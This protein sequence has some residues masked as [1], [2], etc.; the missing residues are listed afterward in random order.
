MSLLIPNAQDYKDARAGNEGLL[1]FHEKLKDLRQRKQ[2][3]WTFEVEQGYFYQS[4]DTTDDLKFN[5]ATSDFGVTRGW[6]EIVD[7][8]HQANTRDPNIHY[9]LLFLARH[10]QG[11]HNI[12]VNK[13][14]SEAWRNKWHA[15]ETD[16]DIKYAPDPELTD[17]GIAQAHENNQVWSEQLKKGC[18]LPTKFFVSPLQRLCETLRLTMKGLMVKDQKII[19]CERIRE[20]IGYHLCNKRSTKSIIVDRFAKYGFEPEDGFTEQDELYSDKEETFEENCLRVNSFLQ[21]LFST[22]DDEVINITSHGGTIKCFLAVTGH[23]NFTI[24]TGGMIPIVLKAT[25]IT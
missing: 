20:I 14:G 10:G 9:K 3:Q 11:Y 18:P 21:D 25:K 12:I 7:E 6:N 1:Q 22:Y 19:I 17:L 5:Y 23:R 24:S 4:V 16:G 2:V 8:L 13:Y 15:L